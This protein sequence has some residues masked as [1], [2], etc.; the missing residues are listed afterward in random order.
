VV[1]VLRKALAKDPDQ[2]FASAALFGAAI[3]QARDEAG[4]APL[5]R[6]RSPGRAK[7]E[8]PGTAGGA[9]PPSLSHPT[10]PT[11][12][13]MSGGLTRGEHTQ[14]QPAA[15]PDRGALPPPFKEERRQ[16]A[17][18]GRRRGAG[19]AVLSLAALL[20]LGAAIVW[21]RNPSLPPSPAPSP[22]NVQPAPPSPTAVPPPASPTGTLVVDAAPWGEVVEVR[23]ATGRRHELGA[24]RYTPMA[25]ALPPGTY[26]VIL[27][28]PGVSEPRTAVATVR[29][30][31]VETVSVVFHRVDAQDYLERTGY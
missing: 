17:A 7:V 18:P 15:R 26:T 16:D 1:P 3:T 9:A 14:T 10:L 31:G 6:L 12:D 29:A 13:P 24:G 28:R 20:G 11:L 22:A 8:S 30:D 19:L 2:R 25:L 27:R 4:V 5:G 21:L 23:D